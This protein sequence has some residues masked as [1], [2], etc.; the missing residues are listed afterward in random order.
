VP[1]GSLGRACFGVWILAAVV[2][3][4]GAA[5]AQGKWVDPYDKGTDAIK[6]QKWTEA[7]ADLTQA[8][9]ADSH[10]QANKITEGVYHED[11][12]PYYY[13]GLAYFNLKQ[14]DKA[15][16]DLTL[17]GQTKMP[18]PLMQSLRTMLGELAQPP[19]PPPPDPHAV[20]TQAVK[21]GN[22]LFAGRH[23]TEAQGKFTDAQRLWPQVPGA[24]E[25][26]T[27]IANRNKYE[28]LKADAAQDLRAS[29]FADA[30]A[31]YAL[32]KQSD[33]LEYDADH[34]DAQVQVAQAAL[35]PRPADLRQNAAKASAGLLADG[36]ELAR[37]HR[38]A[39]A[40]AK[41]Q[42]ALDADRSN[43]GAVEALHKSHE[44]ERLA[45][46]ART[47][48]DQ[49]SV[50]GAR[51]ALQDAQALDAD[52]FVSDGL[53]GALADVL[54]RLAAPSA[55]PAPG[56]SAGGPVAATPP[57]TSPARSSPPPPL[58]DALVA[59][60]KGDMPTTIRLLQPVAAADRG[61]DAAG[62]AAVH[63][64]LGAAYATSALEA[65]SA[66][67]RDRWHSQADGEF[68]VAQS[69]QPGFQLSGRIVSPA[70][71]AMI[72]EARKQ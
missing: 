60:L 54:R 30:V 66:S 64:Y 72:D 57:G 58:Y 10:A 34:L 11:Y 32:A 31:K 71:Q 3:L 42:A 2:A 5:L 41:Y 49:G 67:D 14:T 55:K 39:D 9:A 38:Y 68:K 70:I 37:Q 44:Y 45:L 33:P 28:S 63:A 36:L 12:F 69:A 7:V 40:N 24:S 52:R 21:D 4:P 62:R 6:N 17:A 53:D 15:L 25:G 65:R 16:A 43:T 29:R 18:E 20:A 19:P 26:L 46:A 13:R 1:I 35:A 61:L 59:Y 47:D 22:A 56:R 23:L 27:A 8:I 51:G 48:L 50:D